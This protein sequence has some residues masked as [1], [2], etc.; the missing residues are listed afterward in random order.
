MWSVA[1]SLVKQTPYALI[2]AL[3]LGSQGTGWAADPSKV[4]VVSQ[5]EV[6]ERSKAGKRALETLKEFSASR[7]RIIAAD[8][9]ELK[10]LEREL[11]A[12]EGGLSESARRERAE[13]FRTKFESY[14]KRLGDFNREVQAKQKEMT[15]EYSKK[16]D[17]AAGV[18]AEK[19]GYAAVLDRGSEGTLKVVIYAKEGVDL[20]DAVVKEFDRRFK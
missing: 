18:V 13:Q 5:Q 3:L 9:E 11:K 1:E 17:E 2:I 20:T 16:I 7:Q 14:Q 8:D 12:Q 6:M 10:S 15:D 4:G 19:A